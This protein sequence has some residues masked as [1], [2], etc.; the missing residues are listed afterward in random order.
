MRMLA[1]ILAGHPFTS[2]LD[3]HAGLRRR[4]MERVAA[5]LREMGATI[6]THDGL[7]AF[8]HHRRQAARHRLPH[9]GRQRPGQERHPAG[10]PVRRGRNRRPRAGAEP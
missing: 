8:D 9:A 6:E 1:G 5:P 2:I 4:P 7:P 10:R 3:G